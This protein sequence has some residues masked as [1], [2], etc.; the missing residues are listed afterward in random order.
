MTYF[1]LHYP[2]PVGGV[3]LRRFFADVQEQVYIRMDRVTA[4]TGALVPAGGPPAG[5]AERE[6]AG[7]RAAEGSAI[8]SPAGSAHPGQV[9]G[10]DG[11]RAPHPPRVRAP[12]GA[13]IADD[14]LTCS[15]LV[16]LYSDQYL[17]DERCML[18]WAFFRERIRWHE[19][20]TGER[21]RA[22]IGVRWSASR[23]PLPPEV[24]DLGVL[25]ANTFGARY[26]DAGVARLIR[27]DPLSDAYRAAV[28]RVVDLVTSAGRRE[29]M[30]MPPTEVRF[31]RPPRVHAAFSRAVVEIPGQQP[32]GQAGP[33]A[34]VSVPGPSDSTAD[35]AGPPGEDIARA[36][37]TGDRRWRVTDPRRQGARPVLR[38]SWGPLGPSDD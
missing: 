2:A 16:A 30:T 23:V 20:F 1:V 28:A 7:S 22:L 5:R 9:E 32:A 29:L 38:R 18:E 21:L 14:V 12:T 11:R 26:P 3:Y 35:N 27:T 15:S 13:R 33:T 19:M 25:D 17:L 36:A 4:F 24:A 31:V 10:L 34:S 6:D 37:G 8:Q